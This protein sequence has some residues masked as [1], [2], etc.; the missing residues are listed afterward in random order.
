MAVCNTST[1]LESAKCFSCLSKKELQ[2]VIAQ[3]L[4]NI[5]S[6]GTGVGEVLT[7]SFDDPNGNVTPT[8]TAGAAIYYKDSDTLQMYRW[9]VIQQLWIATITT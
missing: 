4:C 2:A 8:N 1:L 5:S 7:G 6:A 3:L 9:S